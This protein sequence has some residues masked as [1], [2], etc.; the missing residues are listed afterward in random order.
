MILRIYFWNKCETCEVTLYSTIFFFNSSCAICLQKILMKSRLPS[1]IRKY[2]LVRQWCH[3]SLGTELLPF[4]VII[5]LVTETDLEFASSRISI[6]DG[7]ICKFSIY[8]T[9]FGK[10]SILLPFWHLLLSNFFY[11]YQLA[12]QSWINLNR[13]W[14]ISKLHRIKVVLW[15]LLNFSINNCYYH[16]WIK[17]AL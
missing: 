6:S 1:V 3:R 8:Q 17:G 2:N 15:T 13:L 16:N 9:I 11:L 4:C 7:G 14:L 10:N 5:V 12:K